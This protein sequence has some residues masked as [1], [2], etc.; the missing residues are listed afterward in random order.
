MSLRCDTCAAE[1][2]ETNRFCGQCG[3]QLKQLP[4]ED[5]EEF[6]RASRTADSFEHLDAE[7]L[8]P[9]AN[10]PPEVI[11]FDNKIPLFASENADRRLHTPPE[12]LE[13][14]HDH[15]EREEELHDQLSH[16]SET[17]YEAHQ[18]EEADRDDYLRWD[19]QT[20]PAE[21]PN[22]NAAIESVAT[23]HDA[24][25]GF[26]DIDL[27][28]DPTHPP[29]DLRYMP[30]GERTSR[31]GVSGPSFLGLT[32]DQP[33]VYD[34]EEHEPP[35]HLRRNIGIG[36][37]AAFLILVGLQWRSIRDY[38]MA[39]MQNGTMQ[40]KQ[41]KEQT[42]PPAVA[43]TNNTTQ[44]LP[45]PTNASA[46]K[47]IESSPNANHALPVQQAENRAPSE[48]P[49][50]N[51]SR[52]PAMSA[53]TPDVPESH[54]RVTATHTKPKP[55]QLH[56]K[57]DAR[58]VPPHAAPGAS[59]MTRAAKA[60]DSEARAAWLWKAIAKGNPQ[61]P[62]ELAKMYEQG[63]GVVRSCDQAQVLLRSAAAKGNN[64]AK[65]NLQQ[66]RNQG[67]CSSR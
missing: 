32:D 17:H 47:P 11:E 18:Q 64:Q 6:W 38:G 26:T 14:V 57:Q 56:T 53:P 44:S 52:P 51:T 36:I 33:P 13:E 41:Q 27:P 24:L 54:S 25:A 42:P 62:I 48:P 35:S 46:P 10:L 55:R 45:A 4:N 23:Q 40:V 22:M 16:H 31:T 61:A 28:H 20:D 7:H 65:L 34:D 30:D 43:A 39:Y 21:S 19:D 5:P 50:N 67:G 63:R 59:E 8:E 66:I 3:K 37:A 58:A 60:S 9:S 49:A 12:I 2:P 15:L 29:M 1:N